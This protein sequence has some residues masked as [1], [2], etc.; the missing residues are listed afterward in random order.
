MTGIN[1]L[2]KI[3]WRFTLGKNR[4]NIRP[5]KTKNPHVKGKPYRFDVL[6]IATH[7]A[8]WYNLNTRICEKASIITIDQELNYKFY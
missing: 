6:T 5:T 3:L 4:A 7:D 1:E 2:K 8:L